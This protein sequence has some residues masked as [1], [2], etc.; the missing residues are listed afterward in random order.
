MAELGVVSSVTVFFKGVPI[1]FKIEVVARDG[2]DKE[3]KKVA[4]IDA[5]EFKKELQKITREME[6]KGIS[7]SLKTEGIEFYGMETIAQYVIKKLK[8]KFPI[9]Y[10]KVWEGEDEWAIV[11]SNEI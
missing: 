3:T 1:K 6:Y 9:Y 2:I 10:V 11:Y 7:H 8:N 5:I 4:G